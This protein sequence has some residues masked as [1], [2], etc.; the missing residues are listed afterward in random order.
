MV[1]NM[2]NEVEFVTISIPKRSEWRCELFGGGPHGLVFTPVE[3]QEPNWFW[4]WMQY[5]ILGNKWTKK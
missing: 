3:G 5:L 4:R 1:V 2:D